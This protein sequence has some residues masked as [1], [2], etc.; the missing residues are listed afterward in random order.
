MEKGSGIH[1]ILNLRSSYSGIFVVTNVNYAIQWKIANYVGCSHVCTILGC[2]KL[3][4]LVYPCLHEAFSCRENEGILIHKSFLLCA[5][6][7]MTQNDI[8]AAD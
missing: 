2:R 6:Q 7:K 1:A 5:L 3:K 8:E 4:S